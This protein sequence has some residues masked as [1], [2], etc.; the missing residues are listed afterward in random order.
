[1]YQYAT[2]KGKIAKRMTNLRMHL[3]YQSDIAVKLLVAEIEKQNFYELFQQ[4][5]GRS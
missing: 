4:L 3:L 5:R 2:L 1:M